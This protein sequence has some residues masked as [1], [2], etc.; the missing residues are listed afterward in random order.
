MVSTGKEDD[1]L[2]EEA[3]RILRAYMQ[4]QGYNFA[5]LA[6]ALEERGGQGETAQTLSNKINRGRFTFAFF[7]RVARV[8]GISA[9][10]VGPLDGRATS[11]VSV[12][13][14]GSSIE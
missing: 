2:A 3:K 12:T 9:I 4:R 10:S 8:M 6:R 1:E 13:N 5:S 14:D 7:I 11:S